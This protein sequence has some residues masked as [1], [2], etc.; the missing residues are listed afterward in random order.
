VYF[1]SLVDLVHLFQYQK[2]C[3][4]Y[5]ARMSFSFRSGAWLSI[6]ISRDGVYKLIKNINPSKATGPDTNAGRVLK[7]NIDICTDILTLLFTKSLET[8][9]VPSEYEFLISFWSL[10]LVF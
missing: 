8:G 5:I 9:K 7:G 2:S 10:A 6:K 3:F 1:G 4:L